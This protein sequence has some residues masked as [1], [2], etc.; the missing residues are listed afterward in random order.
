MSAND[1]LQAQRSELY[2]GFIDMTVLYHNIDARAA[3]A[4]FFL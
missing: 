2:G 1:P 3:G 4:I